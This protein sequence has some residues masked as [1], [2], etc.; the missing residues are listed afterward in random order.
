MKPKKKKVIA[1]GADKADRRGDRK[2]AR[3]QKRYDRKYEEGGK[4]TYS[5]KK[6][7]QKAKLEADIKK[8][9]GTPDAKVLVERY[10]KLV[11][12]SK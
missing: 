11:G 2:A 10:R 6:E 7:A 5:S 3:A 4:I 1:Q 12:D 8:V 9:K